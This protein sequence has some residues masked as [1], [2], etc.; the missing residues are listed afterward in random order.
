MRRLRA[1]ASPLLL[2]ASLSLPW[3]CGAAAQRQVPG[4]ECRVSRVV[5]GDSFE[6]TRE[7]AAHRVR[8]LGVDAPELAQR[9]YGERSREFVERTMPVGA[10]VGL[11]LDVRERDRYGRLLA[12]V[13]R[14]DTTM[15]NVAVIRA[16]LAA[17]YVLPPNVKY[18]AVL[19]GAADDARR[20]SAGL[21]AT[22]YFTCT[23]TDFRRG[24]C[25]RP[26]AGSR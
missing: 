6:C 8:L 23:A 26:D 20:A 15:V 1:F 19:R 3:A 4:L 22:P 21:W 14:D 25:G 12:W 9:P 24:R 2:A 5:D 7:G 13:W 17:V 10:L 18:A 16:G 11:E